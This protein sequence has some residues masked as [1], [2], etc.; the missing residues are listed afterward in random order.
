[1]P[2]SMRHWMPAQSTVGRPAEHWSRSWP[3]YRTTRMAQLL[4]P[5]GI[6][7]EETSRD[8]S[9]APSRIQVEAALWAS[10]NTVVEQRSP[11]HRGNRGERLHTTRGNA[12]DAGGAGGPRAHDRWVG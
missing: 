4:A 1:M 9:F 5:L 12:L 3:Y 6:S 7:R 11:W 2:N 10:A 8:G